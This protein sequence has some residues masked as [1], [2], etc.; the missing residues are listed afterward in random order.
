ML[1]SFG[2]VTLDSSFCVLP[3]DGSVLYVNDRLSSQESHLDVG[4]VN[5]VDQYFDES[6]H[7]MSPFTN[8]LMKRNSYSNVA[9]N[10]VDDIKKP[11]LPSG[12]IAST[13]K[14]VAYSTEGHISCYDRV[15]KTSITSVTSALSL[16]TKGR[17]PVDIRCAVASRDIDDIF[18]FSLV[19][20]FDIYVL[21]FVQ[22]MQMDGEMKTIAK[23]MLITPQNL[24]LQHHNEIT[25]SNRN[26]GLIAL[27]G[28]GGITLLECHPT[29]PYLYIAGIEGTVQIYSYTNLLQKLKI[30]RSSGGGGGLRSS[31]VNNTDYDNDNEEDEDFDIDD[32]HDDVNPTAK[33]DSAV[34]KRSPTKNDKRSNGGLFSS[35]NKKIEGPKELLHVG[36]LNPPSNDMISKM[37]KDV[38]NQENN[39]SSVD[40]LSSV[41]Q[42]KQSLT[43][44][45]GLYNSSVVS[46]TA[47]KFTIH[48]T[49]L[50]VAVLFSFARVVR[51]YDGDG[52]DSSTTAT[53]TPTSSVLTTCTCVY[54]CSPVFNQPP[55]PKNISSHESNNKT[56]S[57]VISIDIIAFNNVKYHDEMV[58]PSVEQTVE[59]LKPESNEYIN[60]V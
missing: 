26:D 27:F 25:N 20:K 48:H 56:K 57:P 3:E 29:Q 21:Y 41:S 40:G 15:A 22:N 16:M 19:G 55:P 13:S 9:V 46:I 17:R 52:T 34:N 43:K 28:V 37:L 32:D 45:S 38:I 33:D 44:N 58:L 1:G 53:V 54:D 2:S 14:L 59:K 6:M 49:G 60:K 31:N 39:H 50:L 23:I 51:R 30:N 47:S 18:F 4:K 36:V 8:P 7:R 12:L 11:F 5:L 10:D 42:I 35:W 24:I